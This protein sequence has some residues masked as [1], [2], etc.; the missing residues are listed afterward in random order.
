[1]QLVD[2]WAQWRVFLFLLLLLLFSRHIS[3]ALDRH[4]E[5]M[6]NVWA[7]RDPAEIAVGKRERTGNGTEA[8]APA[9]ANGQIQEKQLMS[10]DLGC[11]HNGTVS[12]DIDG[13]S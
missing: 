4:W 7:E 1:M 9:N 8:S 11:W 3:V 10:N 13:G 6:F 5:E 12:T 2:C